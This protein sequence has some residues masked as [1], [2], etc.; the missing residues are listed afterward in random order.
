MVLKI[1]TT[2]LRFAGGH[3]SNILCT[4]PCV[5]ARLSRL[6]FWRASL[7]E[8]GADGGIALSLA[9]IIQYK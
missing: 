4:K 8:K 2:Y 1:R 6:L 9:R 5:S 7:E 3:R